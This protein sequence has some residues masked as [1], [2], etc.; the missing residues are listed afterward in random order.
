[1]E[2]AA[3]PSEQSA[4]DEINSFVSAVLGENEA[5][6][7]ADY[8]KFYGLQREDEVR[9]QTYLCNSQ[10][11]DEGLFTEENV[12]N[13]HIN[14]RLNNP[15]SA[16][17]LFLVWLRKKLPPLPKKIHITRM[18]SVTQPDGTIPDYAL[19]TVCLDETEVV[20][21]FPKK[22]DTGPDFGTLVVSLINGESVDAIEKR[23]FQNE[24]TSSNKEEEEE[25]S[26]TNK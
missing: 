10:I 23:E 16:E 4:M 5:P 12:C 11:D 24:T 20:F 7:I 6:T 15:D 21:Y 26:G 18:E 3:A 2:C 9:F 17:S 19:I 1:M 13:E 8:Y 25:V 14:N 22:Y